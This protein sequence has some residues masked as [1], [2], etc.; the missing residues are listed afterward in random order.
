MNSSKLA[1]LTFD[2]GPNTVTTPQVLDVLEKH[3]VTA[4]F[5]VIGNNITPESSEVMLRAVKMGC[6]IENHSR[7]H[8]DMTK[9]SAGEISAEIS[10]TSGAIEKAAGRRPEFFRPPY[11]AC[12]QQMFDTI[13]LTFICGIGADDWNEEISADERFRRITEQVSDG[14]VILL[15]DMEGN[16]RTVE[17]I[18]RIIPAMKAD[19]YE[20]VTVSELFSRKG[21]VPKKNIIYTNVFQDK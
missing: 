7:T 4:T 9:M 18:D 15:H 3:N 20:F 11:I 17:A 5:F 14:S 13:D 16:F 1:A 10:F 8:S 6:G 21:I 19:G 12:G 2:D